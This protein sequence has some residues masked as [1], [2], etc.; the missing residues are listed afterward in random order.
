MIQL[1]LPHVA[2]PKALAAEKIQ[3]CRLQMTEIEARYAEK[4]I[5][6]NSDHQLV[7]SYGN[8]IQKER[9]LEPE[10]IEKRLHSSARIVKVEE[11]YKSGFPLLLYLIHRPVC[12]F[13]EIM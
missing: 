2:D 11:F 8:I 6:I 13:H 12:L 9:K 7:D 3:K 10:E 4:G 1:D 5:S